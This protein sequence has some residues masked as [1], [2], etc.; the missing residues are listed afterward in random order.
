[1]ISVQSDSGCSDKSVVFY[2]LPIIIRQMRKKFSG[3]I[4]KWEVYKAGG[5]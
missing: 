2:H 1:M 4:I 3:G 5:E